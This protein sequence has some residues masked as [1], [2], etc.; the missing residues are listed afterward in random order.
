MWLLPHFCGMGA[1]ALIVSQESLFKIFREAQVGLFLV[2]FATKNVNVK[3]A[4]APFRSAQLC[5]AR[6]ASWS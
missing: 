4:H 1:S 6:F 2:A 3:H 5:R